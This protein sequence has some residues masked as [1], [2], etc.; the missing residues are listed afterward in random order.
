MGVI[1]LVLWKRHQMKSQVGEA[2]Q[3]EPVGVERKGRTLQV[4]MAFLLHVMHDLRTSLH[5]LGGFT[6]LIKEDEC[7]PSMS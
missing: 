1:C 2:Q 7:H 3:K 4:N 6:Y 5:S